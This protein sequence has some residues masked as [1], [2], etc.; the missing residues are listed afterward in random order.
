[1]LFVA[2]GALSGCHAHVT[3]DPPPPPATA[4]V[5]R[6]DYFA[7]HRAR[8]VERGQLEAHTRLFEMRPTFSPKNI[9][10]ANGVTV[11]HADDL[12]QL[13]A[14]DSDSGRA[15]ATAQE[16]GA[17]ADLMTGIGYGIAGVAG[18]GGGTLLAL[19]ITST[20]A[21]PPGP[22]PTDVP[23]ELY[24][25]GACAAAALVGAGVVMW[26]ATIGDDARDARSLAFKSFDEGLWQKLALEGAPPPPP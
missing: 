18:A 9:V 21:R 4:D 2:L 20:A 13:V 1:V 16:A 26:G 10:L 3:L 15:I 12:L 17:R 23:A 14:A 25:V 5:T 11:H 8:P 22:P 6:R 24:A 7:T 19:T